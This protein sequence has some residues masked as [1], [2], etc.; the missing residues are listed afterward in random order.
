MGEGTG[1]AGMTVREK[2]EAVH[3]YKKNGII[4]TPL[5]FPRDVIINR[6]IRFLVLI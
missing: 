2:R 5:D 3:M 6:F 1:W 4:I